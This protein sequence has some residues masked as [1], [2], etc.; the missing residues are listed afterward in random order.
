MAYSL[1]DGKGGFFRYIPGS[2]F[3]AEILVDA[4]FSAQPD[5][6]R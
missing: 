6:R 5:C 4:F 2:F 3:Y 1:I